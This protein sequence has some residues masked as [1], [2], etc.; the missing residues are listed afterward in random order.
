[1]IH[2]VVNRI[3][4]VVVLIILAPERGASSDELVRPPCSI[5][6]NDQNSYENQSKGGTADPV[7][8]HVTGIVKHSMVENDRE[9]ND[10][11]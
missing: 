7:H 4:L 8:S 10:G 9:L 11:D 6:S 3:L 1:M 5:F 2:A